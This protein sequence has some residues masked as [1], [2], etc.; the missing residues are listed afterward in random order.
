LGAK[1]VTGGATRVDVPHLT[2]VRVRLATP[3]PPASVTGAHVAEKDVTEDTKSTSVTPPQPALPV[4]SRTP[5]TTGGVE[6]NVNPLEV[7]EAG[8]PQV[9]TAVIVASNTVPE[10]M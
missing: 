7:P 6:S 3:L 2:K 9:L 8:R 5:C 1:E 10:M 4:P